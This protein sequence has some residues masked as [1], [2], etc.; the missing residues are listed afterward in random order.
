MSTDIDWR[1]IADE[2]GTITFTDGGHTESGGTQIATDALNIIVGNQIAVSAVDFYLSHVPGYE[3]ARSILKLLR[4]ADAT[5]RCLEI[6]R[7]SPDSDEACDAVELLR[8]I[9]TNAT[10]EHFDEL[11]RSKNA[12]TRVWT[13]GM[14]DDL[15]M[16]GEL[17]I[18]DG[19][20]YLEIALKDPDQGVV[21]RA[22]Y[23]KELWQR[24]EQF[25]SD[26][27]AS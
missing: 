11:F 23:L 26:E 20:P 3:V 10:L 25:L 2:L 5:H 12:R 24:E 4:P 13:V 16:A 15:W 22:N 18:D 8:S 14:L 6:F 1:A 17:E 27:E 7:H 21:T 9:A 19:Q